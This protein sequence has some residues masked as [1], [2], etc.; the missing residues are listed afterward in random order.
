MSGEREERDECDTTNGT[1]TDRDFHKIQWLIIFMWASHKT[2]A[3][4]S[5]KGARD[6]GIEQTGELK[7]ENEDL[8]RTERATRSCSKQ[9]CRTSELNK[10]NI[11]D[12]LETN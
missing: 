10:E 4:A 9:L 7:L 8:A 6:E 12:R 3:H 2:P 1:R 5:R 11:V